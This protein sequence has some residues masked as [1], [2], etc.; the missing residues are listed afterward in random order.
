MALIPVLGLV[1]EERATIDRAGLA[2]GGRALLA[3]FGS[4]D[5]W[6]I[7][8]FLFLYYFSP[9]FG[10]PLYFELTD[11]LGFSQ[12]YIG[13]LS[14]ATALG[15][16]AGGLIY[17]YALARVEARKLLTLSLLFGAASTL[18]YLGLVDRISA[19]AIYFTGGVAGMIANTATFSLA[20]AHC[21]KRAEGFTFAA[22][23]SIINF[24][25]PLADTVGAALYEHVFG[26]RMAPL[27][28]VSTASTLAILVLVPLVSDR[29]G[30]S[31]SKP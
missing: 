18:A 2:A 26:G 17:R 7:A 10:T 31:F 21:P 4:R 28:L 16:V 29:P 22:M 6:L 24:A 20:A 3:A 12:G 19:V 13:F 8:G 23:M 30:E 14:A 11:K 27:I 25:H 9:G 1:A 5:L 15:W